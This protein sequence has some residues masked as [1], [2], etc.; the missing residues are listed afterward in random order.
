MFHFEPLGGRI[1]ARIETRSECSCGEQPSGD[2]LIHSPR[3]GL[4]G[5]KLPRS[6]F[7]TTSHPARPDGITAGRAGCPNLPAQLPASLAC[8]AARPS[9][10]AASAVYSLMSLS[11]WFAMARFWVSL[12]PA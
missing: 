10:S 12:P 4:P 6:A 7:G 2:T 1:Y 9:Y 5:H 8:S 3:L 11:Q